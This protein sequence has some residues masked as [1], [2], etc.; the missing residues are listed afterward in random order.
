MR[1]KSQAFIQIAFG[2][3]FM[4]WCSHSWSQGASRLDSIKT[5]LEASNDKSERLLLLIDLGEVYS[6]SSDDSLYPIAKEIISLS[7]ELN[8]VCSKSTGY[9]YC[10]NYYADNGDIDGAI[11][12]Y[13]KCLDIRQ[14]SCSKERI[15]SVLM[16][17]GNMFGHKGDYENAYA[18]YFQSLDIYESV[19]DY[20]GAAQLYSNLSV[21]DNERGDFQSSLKN[22]EKALQSES[23]NQSVDTINLGNIYNNFG[24]IYQAQEKYDTAIYYFNKAMKL[25]QKKGH[26]SGLSHGFNNIGIC[27]YF[28]G[29]AD[30]TMAYFKKSLEIRKEIGDF[31][32]ISQ[33]YNNIS[34]LYYYQENYPLATVY[35]DSSLELA[36]K[37]GFKEEI[38]EAYLN[39]YD[40]YFEWGEYYDAC[41]NLQLYGTY[42][43]SI[44][45]EE[46]ERA[47]AFLETKYET[48]KKEKELEEKNQALMLSEASS[49]R[50]NLILFGGGFILFLLAW[51]A[52][53]TYSKNKITKAQN[54]IIAEQK[55]MVEE[56]QTEILDSIRYAKRIQ[57]ALLKSEEHESSHLPEHFVIFKPKDIVSGDFY[58]VHEVDDYLYLAVADCTGHGVPGGFLTMLG[59]SFLNEIISKESTLKPAQILDELRSR[60]VKELSQTGEIGENRDGMDISLIRLNLKTLEAQWSGANNPLWIIKNKEHE[61]KVLSEKVHVHQDLV[62]IRPDK[63]PIG[64]HWVMTPFTNHEFQ[65]EKGDTFYLFSDGFADQFGGEKGKKLKYKNKKEILLAIKAMSM[66]EKKKHLNEFFQKWKGDY[67]QIDDVCLVGMQV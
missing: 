38:S 44:R 45:T 5:A 2:V 67:E 63:Q 42:T 58:W 66:A 55:L 43:D 49:K 31:R 40:I 18:Y 30:S 21:L 35:A 7:D 27:Y 39:K 24:T 65:L 23:K 9:F 6:H 26:K 16:V 48:V 19:N 3:L 13:Q 41:I 11:D 25:Y 14:K 1:R 32:S 56:K 54:A 29:H 17:I 22:V 15:A 57:E 64:H 53:S 34:I 33:S 10:G 59:A 4:L 8:D 36:L 47:I 12:N 37:G 50:K 60:M 46:G 61:T 51:F 62:E 52:R 28:N 20:S